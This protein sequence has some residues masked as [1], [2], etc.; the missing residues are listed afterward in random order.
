VIA[1][2]AELIAVRRGAGNDPGLLEL[3][4]MAERETVLR[5]GFTADRDR[6][7]TAR[8]A[9]RLELGRRLGVPPACVPLVRQLGG[10][11]LVDGMG[12]AVS[13]SH[14]GSWVALALAEDRA[15][16]VDIERIPE[17]VPI[18]ALVRFGMRS[19]A[20]F[21]AREAAGKVTGQGLAGGSPPGVRALVLRAPAGYLAAVAAPGTDWRVH[22]AAPITTGVLAP[23]T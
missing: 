9:A 22:A 15:V 18:E 12:L 10:K 14:S 2:S 11:P 20:D 21:V 16:G 6:A 4:S 1:V 19:L 3:L 7:V 5:L 17:R 23:R 13:W 8:A